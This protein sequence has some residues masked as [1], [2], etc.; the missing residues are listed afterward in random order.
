[1]NKI[2]SVLILSLI[3]AISGIYTPTALADRI[4]TFWERGIGDDFPGPVC[5]I[6]GTGRTV[7][8]MITCYNV[9]SSSDVSFAYQSPL[10]VDS[11]KRYVWIYTTSDTSPP[12][13]T[14]AGIIPS[15]MGG[16]VFGFYEP[17][18][19]IIFSQ[20]SINAGSISPSGSEVWIS[21][22]TTPITA[23]PSYG[24][25]FDSWSTTGAVVIDDPNSQNAHVTVS[26]PGT[27]KA[28]FLQTVGQV[29][30][31][32]TPSVTGHGSII[33]S[34][35]IWAD[36]GENWTFT[37]YPEPGYVVSTIT[38]DGMPVPI[39]NHY[40]FS[41]V[42]S[43]HKI[44]VTFEEISKIPTTIDSNPTREKLI[45]VDGNLTMTPHTFYWI[46]GSVHTLAATS[47]QN[48]EVGVRYNFL[49]WSDSG[50]QT[51]NYIASDTPTIIKANYTTQYLLT[52]KTNTGTVSPQS[53]TWYNAGS[54]ITVKAE[55]PTAVEGESFVFGG[56]KG[57]FTGYTGG[58]NPS[59]E[60]IMNRPI[61]EE[62][63]WQHAYELKIES[64]YGNATNAG[65]YEVNEIVH[66]T[67]P[68]TVIVKNN[69][70]ARFIGWSGD[71]SGTKS[72]SDAITMNSPKRVKAEWIT[73]YQLVFS[74][75]GLD[76][77]ILGIGNEA[78]L[79]VNGTSLGIKDLPY[80]TG[81]INNGT[82]INYS[83]KNTMITSLGLVYKLSNSETLNPT[84]I[85][86]SS[87]DISAPYRY[88][89]FAFQWI[90]GLILLLILLII[91]IVIVLY[92]RRKN[93]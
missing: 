47:T 16:N 13:T 21:E 75:S 12:V 67:I 70:C 78:V 72:I 73:Q 10:S 1:M 45:L 32:I 91:G 59:A 8:D 6:E 23:S 35:A 15:D 56:W 9:Y 30:Y 24:Y 60:I 18:Y 48:G 86:G 57:S 2:R 36:E 79:V 39:S 87:V 4:I 76:G 33:P 26:G 62:T 53:G 93:P 46:P 71:A 58:N 64:A 82:I 31:T 27:I 29:V 92:R 38:V 17:Q 11:S 69:V 41:N 85:V 43:N 63:K 37:F 51:R 81:W 19:K 61:T 65:W 52:V 40:T 68:E 44:D 88:E 50:E 90:H 83:F 42:R 7:I 55:A 34:M 54:R 14:Q 3:L 80:R 22:G 5:N 20:S 25:T 66:A 28:N 74:Q 77:G 89:T 49:S 84:M